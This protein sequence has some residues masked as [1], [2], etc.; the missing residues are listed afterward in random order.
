VLDAGRAARS[1]SDR[2]HGAVLS[3]IRTEDLECWIGE[4]LP[5]L[6]GIDSALLCT[7]GAEAEDPRPAVRS[8]PPG[9]VALLLGSR[10]V[11]IG[12]GARFGEGRA[13]PTGAELHGAATGLA[14]H[15]A[16]LRVPA[17]GRPPMLLALGSRNRA[18]LEEGLPA[19]S[20]GTRALAFL[21]EA[22]AARMEGA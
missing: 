20:G 5:G 16:L 10:D 6:L 3:L 14:L 15:D 11:R 19:G 2:V 21:G 13:G 17:R 12:D 1:L 9:T 22:V 4:E 7:E 8:L 18:V